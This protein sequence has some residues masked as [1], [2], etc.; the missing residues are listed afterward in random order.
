MQQLLR[1]KDVLLLKTSDIAPPKPFVFDIN[2]YLREHFIRYF[3]RKALACT[4][5]LSTLIT[6]SPEILAPILRSKWLAYHHYCAGRRER[7]GVWS[8][9]QMMCSARNFICFLND[10]SCAGTSILNAYNL[11]QEVILNAV[12]GCDA[13]LSCKPP[14][15]SWVIIPQMHHIWGIYL[16]WGAW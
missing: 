9:V 1:F 14:Y 5:V 12:Y 15:Y 13:S 6:S 11:Y 7:G 8:L 4:F 10:L 3:T 2:L 16:I